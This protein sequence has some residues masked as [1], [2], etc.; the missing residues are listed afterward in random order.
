MKK[1]LT[2][3]SV[4]RI[5]ISKRRFLCSA[6]VHT[7][8]A[9]WLIALAAQISVP[10][11]PVPMTMQT[12]AI[13]LVALLTPWSTAIGAVL[14]YLS[15]AAVGLPVLAGGNSGLLGLTG[16]TAGFLVGLV[17]MS[18]V[19]AALTQRY[20]DRAIWVR[21]G[22]VLTGSLCAFVPGLSLLTHLFSWEVAFKTGLLPFVF[23]EPAKLALAAYLSVFIQNK[24]SSKAQ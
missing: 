22:F 13:A 8:C 11:Y 1:L 19:I 21:F 24:Y 7:F 10:F 17:W 16:P 20:K 14:L 3:T 9:S 12:F 15:Y 18:G 4:W 6:F 23:S 2:L 5:G